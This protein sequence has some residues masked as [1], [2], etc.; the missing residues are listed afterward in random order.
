M[1]SFFRIFELLLTEG[2]HQPSL[3][4]SESKPTLMIVPKIILM[5]DFKMVGL[6]AVMK[7]QN[8]TRV[9]AKL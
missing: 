4:L 2:C 5:A 8:E 9:Q 1:S 3:S 6:L 7:V